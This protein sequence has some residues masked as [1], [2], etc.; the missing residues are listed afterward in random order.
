MAGENRTEKPTPKRREE[1]RKRGQIAR[2]SDLNGA[3]VLF[4]SI[5]VLALVGPGILHRLEEVVATGLARSASPEEAG[6][7][8]I[9]G[10]AKWMGLALV[11]TA[12]PVAFAAALAAFLANVAQVRLRLTPRAATPSLRAF[13]PVKGIVRIF[14]P[15]GLFEGAKATVK[16]TVIS[17]VAV[18]ALAPSIPHLASL[19]GL[20]A[21]ALLPTLAGLVLGIALRVAAAFL[22]IALVDFAWQ[23][24][25]HEKSLRMTKEEV[26]QEMRQQ[27]IA[28]EVRG[29]IRRRQR[30]QARRRMLAEVPTADVVVTNPTHFAVALRYDGQVPA[31]EVVA[32][33]ADLVAAAIRRIAEEHAIP[34]VRNPSLARALHDEVEL[35]QMVPERFYAAVAEVLAF[36]YRTAGRPSRE[37]RRRRRRTLNAAQGV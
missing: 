23:K 5:A 17:A 16:M 36:V 30:E 22:L 10:L 26:K 1:A 2:S 9:G 3:V 21:D 12:G 19:V 31:P 11:Q 32:K 35:G 34:L 28:P 14:G 29:A 8:A 15:Q 27:D 4:A 7:Q 24:R 13:N 33:G 37:Q 20:P 6:P 18:L 25:R